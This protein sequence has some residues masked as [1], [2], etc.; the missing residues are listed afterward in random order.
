VSSLWTPGGEYPV[1][2]QP[3]AERDEQ[4]AP[5]GADRDFDDIDGDPLAGLS[6]ED[7]VRAEQMAADMDRVRQEL[8]SVPAAVVVANHAM[9]LFELA[10]IHL[11]N[12]PPNLSEAKL[13]IDGM[14]V[15]VDG[16]AGRLGP[17][18]TVLRDSLGQIRLAFVQI[19]T[20][21][22]GA[23]SEPADEPH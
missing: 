5:D 4:A 2:R 22:S 18:E 7:R 13:A 9:G 15:L 23:G 10:A 16:L 20:G 3:S 11:S 12:D 14:G 1:E 19:Q 21:R 17:N 6:P 8:A